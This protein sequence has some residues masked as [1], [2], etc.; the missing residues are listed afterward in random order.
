MKT[1]DKKEL[2]TKEINELVKI[3]K[4]SEDSLLT[5]RLNKVQNKLKNTRELFNTRKKIAILR[6]VI[7]EKELIKNA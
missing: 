2:H 3:L 6:S 7:R 1:N 5:Y 4:E